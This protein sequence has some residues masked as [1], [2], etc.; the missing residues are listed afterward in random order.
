MYV[1]EAKRGITTYCSHP[2]G[3]RRAMAERRPCPTA[4]LPLVIQTRHK[5]VL[6]FFFL[7]KGDMYYSYSQMTFAAMKLP[8]TNP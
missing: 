8:K 3:T 2:L 1:L 5:V 7:E 6:L 4:I